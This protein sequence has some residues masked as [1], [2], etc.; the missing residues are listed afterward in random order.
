MNNIYTSFF[1]AFSIIFIGS[2]LFDPLPYS[3]ILKISPLAVLVTISLP[4]AQTTKHKLFIA[5]LVFSSFGYIFLDVNRSQFFIYG[6]GSFLTA[7]IFY[8]ICFAPL[9]NIFSSSNPQFKSQLLAT[10]G[11][12]VFGLVMFS[13]IRPGLGEL[14]LPVLIYMS[15]LMLMGVFALL[16]KKSNLWLILGGVSFIISD[17]I[18]GIDKF[19]LPIPNAGILIMLSYYF[20]QFSLVRGMFFVTR[21]ST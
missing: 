9:S 7:H 6:L 18:I 13:Y 17:S 19:Y 14:F 4:H 3:W 11:F 8:M 16:S 2:T 15:V 12:L 20:A 5:G 10:L 1:I 21:D